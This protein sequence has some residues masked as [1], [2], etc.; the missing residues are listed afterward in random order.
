MEILVF[1]WYQYVLPL[2]ASTAVRQ[3]AGFSTFF[4]AMAA[5]NINDFYKKTF[6]IMP[7]GFG[8]YRKIYISF[9]LSH[10]KNHNNYHHG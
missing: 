10:Q 5:I 7:Y 6:N 9:F 2:V 8:S 4:P 1:L 3:S